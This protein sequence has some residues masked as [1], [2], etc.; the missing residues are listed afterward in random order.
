MM[1]QDFFQKRNRVALAFSGGAD[2]A[3][4][5]SVGKQSGCDI[6]PYYVKTPFQTQIEIDNAQYLADVIGVPLKTL[7][8]DV[9]SLPNIVHNKNDRCYHC[10]HSIFKIIKSAAYAVGCEMIIDGTN[11][12]DDI[13][14]R[15]G[16]Q[17]LRELGVRS[18]LRE[19]GLSKSQIRE[20]SRQIGLSTWNK[21]ANACLATRIPIG[22]PIKYE[23]L[24]KVEQA[25]NYL[26]GLG[27]SD[28]RVRVFHE[29]AKIQ[30]LETQFDQVCA[31]RLDILNHLS[32]YF[33]EIF[34]DL[35]CRNQPKE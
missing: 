13:N 24:Q 28:F 4:L 26:S 20:A 21:P 9:L 33:N 15:P 34:I 12:S 10:K 17:A 27:F 22:T 6:Y 30:L 16:M 23:T 31:M 29:G 35:H 1:I 7:Q 8:F 5:L 11:A 14:D 18:P 19:C 2:S 32:Q 25:E 3:F